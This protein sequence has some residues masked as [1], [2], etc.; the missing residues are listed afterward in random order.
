MR[1]QYFYHNDFVHALDP[2][3]YQLFKRVDDDWIELRH[4]SEFQCFRLKAVELTPSEV[5]RYDTCL[6]PARMDR[7]PGE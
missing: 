1:F 2:T 4:P 7:L 3:T 6:M 5:S